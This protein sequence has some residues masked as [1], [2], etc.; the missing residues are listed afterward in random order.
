MAM[1]IDADIIIK[2]ASLLG[3]IGA[4]IAAIV[5]IYKV[6]EINRRQSKFINAIQKEQQIICYGLRGALQGLVEQGCNGPCRDAL[7]RLDKHLN[8]NAHPHI[9]GE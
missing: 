6:V 8:K 3:A 7:D 1:Y 9:G 5:S 4:L 2:A